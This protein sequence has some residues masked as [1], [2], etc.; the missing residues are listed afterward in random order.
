MHDAAKS[1][2]ILHVV[3]TYLPATR[4]GGPIHSVHGLCRALVR[5]GHSVSVAT[6]TVDGDSDSDVPTGRAVP[7]DGVS[8]WYFPATAAML[9]KGLARR[10]YVSRE[11][12]KMLDRSTPSFDM[13]HLHSVYLWPTWAAARSARSHAIP[14]VLSPRGMLVP[15]LIRQRNAV[16][17][18]TWLV[19]IERRNL[20]HAAAVH[21]TSQ[22][23]LSDARKTRLPLP[24]PFVVPNGVDLVERRP[25]EERE[26]S[27]ILYLGRIS[28]KKAID[29]LI[30]A[31]RWLPSVKLIVAGNDDEGL[32]PRLEEL[33]GRFG[34]AERV[35]F[36]G[37]VHGEEKSRLLASCAALVLPSHSENF[38]NV[39][40]EAMA[41]GTP[42][43]VTPQVGIAD[44]VLRCGSGIVIDNDP[45][46]LAKAIGEIL[47]DPTTAAEM[48]NRGRHLVEQEFTWQS[49]A[50]RMADEYRR[51]IES[52]S[53]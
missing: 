13:V 3:P 34:V 45:A 49:A 24:C 4:Y 1:L 19:T 25:S 44:A 37:P 30:E 29:R 16:V 11:M 2:R 38:G 22:R 51:I 18:A 28:W 33:A 43:I 32:T 23:E 9:P 15:E 50:S 41:H 20:Q 35:R 10:L 47:A 46:Q 53:Q 42:V 26:R 36:T 27:T 39:V 31:M 7:L 40:L 17:K 6:T 52:R 5:N 48:G 21:V 14:Y 12:A 8:V